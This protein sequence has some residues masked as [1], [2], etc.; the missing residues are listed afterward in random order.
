VN[1]LKLA[2]LFSLLVFFNCSSMKIRVF[3]KKDNLD[4]VSRV[5]YY[6]ENI[7]SKSEEI[8]YYGNSHNPSRIIYKIRSGNRLVPYKEEEYYFVANNLVKLS[9]FIYKNEKRLNT[10][11]IK[12]YYKNNMQVRIEYYSLDKSL[13]KII[14]FGL[15]QYEYSEGKLSTRRIIEYEVNPGTGK[16]M[17]IGHFYLKY[18]SGKIESMKLS[19]LDRKSKKIIEKLINDSE[20]VYDKIDDIE[21]Y[22]IRRSRGKD[23]F[24]Q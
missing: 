3:E 18:K 13:N 24:K 22:Y 11:M 4:R 23:F 9:F 6:K 17:Q 7:I 19:I 14:I 21:K 1:F 12:Y 20:L 16:P 15:D 5:F 8:K 2:I 10:G